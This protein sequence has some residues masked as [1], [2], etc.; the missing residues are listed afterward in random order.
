MPAWGLSM[1]DEA[2]WGMVAFLRWLPGRSPADYQ[3][4][5]AASSGHS[6]D[7]THEHKHGEHEK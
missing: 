7:G 1:D 6:H 2:I 5:V 4:A 3:A